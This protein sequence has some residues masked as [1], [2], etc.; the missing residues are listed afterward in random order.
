MEVAVARVAVMMVRVVM[1]EAAAVGP[2][3]ATEAAVEN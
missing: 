3:G 2:V 1:A